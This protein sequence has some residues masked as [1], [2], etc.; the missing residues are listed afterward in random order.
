MFLRTFIG[1]Q[2]SKPLINSRYIK[3]TKF[4]LRSKVAKRWIA[5]YCPAGMARSS[6]IP[7]QAKK[8]ARAIAASIAIR[9]WS[10]ATRIFLYEIRIAS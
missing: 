2:S 8:P 3:I 4:I 10:F 5:V 7:D 9:T 1:N 6:E